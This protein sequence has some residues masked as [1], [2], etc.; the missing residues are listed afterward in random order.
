[1]SYLLCAIRPFIKDF[2]CQALTVL[3]RQRNRFDKLPL[4]SKEIED[5]SEPELGRLQR[6]FI[7]FEISRRMISGFDNTAKCREVLSN[8]IGFHVP[9]TVAEICEFNTVQ[10]YLERLVDEVFSKIERFVEVRAKEDEMA[11]AMMTLLETATSSEEAKESNLKE[12]GEAS[13]SSPSFPPWDLYG[14][15]SRIFQAYKSTAAFLVGLGLPFCRVFL[16]EMSLEQQ[17]VVVRLAMSKKRFLNM[18]VITFFTILMF[19][20]GPG[21]DG[22][23]LKKIETNCHTECL[24]RDRPLL[25]SEPEFMVQ[26]ARA[27]ESRQ[28]G[29]C[30]WSEDRLEAKGCDEVFCPDINRIS[31][32][33]ADKWAQFETMPIDVGHSFS[34]SLHP[35]VFEDEEG[36]RK[37]VMNNDYASSKVIYEFKDRINRTDSIR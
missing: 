10:E 5:P 13:C 23:A 29:C 19:V 22:A 18:R 17:M 9:M 21:L 6:A 34:R 8:M 36:F 20:L 3:N 14:G 31:F 15:N 28:A 30:F 12:E 4:E 7:W 24:Y 25:S 1:M 32:L 26:Q 33:L 16:F 37:Y 35:L 11:A 2:S 27:Y